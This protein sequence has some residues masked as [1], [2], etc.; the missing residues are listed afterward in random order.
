VRIGANP[1]IPV[2][3]GW[4]GQIDEVRIYTRALSAQEVSNLALD[5]RF[6]VS[7]SQNLNA[8]EDTAYAIVL[9]ASDADE[10]FL[11]FSITNGPSYGVLSGTAPNLTYVPN[12]DF[13]GSDSFDFEV[14]DSNGGIVSATIIIEVQ[15]VNDAPVAIADAVLTEENVA[16]AFMLQAIDS[17]GDSI[18]FNVVN[19]PSYGVL[20]GAG[21]NLTYTPN[22]GYSG[23]DSFDFEAS[24]GNGG[25]NSATI[26]ITITPYGIHTGDL[27]GDGKSDLIDLL[28][29][30]RYLV[31]VDTLTQEELERAD[32]YPPSVGDGV[33]DISD[34]LL[35][36]RMCLEGVQ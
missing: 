4:A 15:A 12:P 30:Q 5:N 14:I 28:L 9:T 10:D 19:E 32:I 33:V 23:S 2:T 22:T 25:T 20:S 29:M 31:R 13:S 11:S 17:D 26:S 6:P 1:I 36:Q 24:D 3:S 35:L 27:N 18:S 7:S 16:V 34:M 8:T 21:A